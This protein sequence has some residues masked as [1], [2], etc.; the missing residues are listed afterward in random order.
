MLEVRQIASSTFTLLSYLIVEPCSGEMIVIDPPRDILRHLDGVPLTLKAVINTHG[1]IDHILGNAALAVQ[2][3]ILAHPGDN[4]VLLR[5]LNA[6][7]T[8]LLSR[9]ISPRPDYSLQEGQTLCLGDESL[10]VLH[11][12]GH[13]PGSICLAW[14]NN[15]VSGDTLFAGGIGRVDIPGGSAEAM[16]ASLTRLSAL[17]DATRIWPGHFYGGAYSTTMGEN[18]RALVWSMNLLARQVP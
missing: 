15:L 1:H 12:P 6:L 8:C 17:P 4:T 3:P 14:E 2:A 16:H 10:T 7:L 18:R 9:R 13:S 11:T 5:G